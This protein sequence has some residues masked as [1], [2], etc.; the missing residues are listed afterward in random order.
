MEGWPVFFFKFKF[1]YQHFALRGIEA[2]FAWHNSIFWT[3]GS[4]GF[5]EGHRCHLGLW[6][7]GTVVSQKGT[8]ATYDNDLQTVV[9]F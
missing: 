8:A 6:T 3:N 9:I 4:G 7:N 5:P 2:F 1:S